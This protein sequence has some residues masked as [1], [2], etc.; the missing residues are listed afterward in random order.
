MASLKFDL[1]QLDYTTRFSLW[2]VNMRVILAQI[3]DL[4]DAIDGFG[5]KL[6]ASWTEEEKQKDRKVLSLI[7]LHLSNNILLEVLQENLQWPMVET[8]INLHVKGSNQLVACEDEVFLTKVAGRCAGDESP[9]D[10]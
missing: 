6:V 8:G 1:L 2:Q 9:I 3:S 5:K 7:Q 10:L 4:D